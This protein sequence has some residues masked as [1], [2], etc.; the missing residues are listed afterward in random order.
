MS[1]NSKIFSILISDINTVFRID[2]AFTLAASGEDEKALNLCDK[3]YFQYLEKRIKLTP[4]VL[5]ALLLRSHLL[6]NAG[7][8]IESKKCVRLYLSLRNKIAYYN[9]DEKKCMNAYALGML[10]LQKGQT[11]NSCIL[12]IRRNIN[13]D[14]GR[15]RATV[16]NRIRN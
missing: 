9:A 10:W 16:R 7:D 12:E 11:S 4:S 3:T 13:W 6:I 2:K 1:A 8:L 14:A 5:E 15:V